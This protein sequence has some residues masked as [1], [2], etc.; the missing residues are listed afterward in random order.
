M[1]DRRRSAARRRHTLGA[2]PAVRPEAERG[3]LKARLHR[4]SALAVT[5]LATASCA[6]HAPTGPPPAASADPCATTVCRPAKSIIL[7]RGTDQVVF[8]SPA[9]RYVIDDVVILEPGDDIYVT[10]D[11]RDGRLV[12][13]RRVDPPGGGATNVIHLRYKQD[14]LLNGAFVMMLELQSS[15]P[16]VLVYLAAAMGPANPMFFTSTCPVKPGIT[17]SEMWPQPLW[18]VLL[19]NF[20]ASDAA[21][22]CKIY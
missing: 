4:L 18:Q 9:M 11:E 12:N 7:Q 14:Q 13:L 17:A 22:I 16:R 8:N 19:S 5:G 10:G 21:R 6:A 15:F 20:R 1:R 3:G 2:P